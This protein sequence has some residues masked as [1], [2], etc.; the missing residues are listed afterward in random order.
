MATTAKRPFIKYIL[1]AVVLLA[2][3]AVG[4]AA[5]ASSAPGTALKAALLALEFN[6]T[7]NVLI[8]DQYNNRVIEVD[9]A[10]NIVWQFGDESST[11]GPTSVVAP[12]DAERIGDY[13]LISGT[14]APPGSEPDCAEGC[15]DNR[16]LLVGPLGHI[17]W[18]LGAVAADPTVATVNTPVSARMTSKFDILIADQGNQR[19]IL[20]GLGKKILWQYGTTGTAGSGPNELN[21]PNSAEMLGNGDVLIADESNNRVIEVTQA[22]EIVWSYG[23]PADTTILNGPAFASRLP[24]GDTL[25]TDSGNNRI[26]Q[27]TPAGAIV[28]G[29]ATNDRLGSV[30]NPMPTRAVRLITGGTLIADQFNNQVFLVDILHLITFA[31]GIVGVTGK[32]PE[33]LDAPYDAKVIGSYYGLTLPP[34]LL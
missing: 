20:V 5:A 29:Y 18:E 19:V 23:N 17:V 21:N 14:G 2:V 8:A 10:H 31:Q 4:I 22:N 34:L 30:A 26:I 27:V 15:P 28:W 13:T 16:V 11:A 25:I 12:N 9:P 1:G 3:S 6:K 24:G 32:G 33:F 7:G